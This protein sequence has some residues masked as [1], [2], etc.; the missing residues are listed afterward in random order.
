V[1]DWEAERAAVRPALPLPM[2]R[3][4]GVRVGMVGGGLNEVVKGVSLLW[5][6]RL[7][8]WMR[9]FEKLEC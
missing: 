3:T 9:A 4:S 8:V 5:E 2:I 6:R 7:G 1:P